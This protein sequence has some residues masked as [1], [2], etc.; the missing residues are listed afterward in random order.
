[1]W[2]KPDASAQTLVDQE[3]TIPTSSSSQLEDSGCDVSSECAFDS[4]GAASA[5][6]QPERDGSA[7]KPWLERA[8]PLNLCSPS[9]EKSLAASVQFLQH[10]LEIRQL[11]EGGILQADFTELEKDSLAVCSSV[12]RLLEG[13]TVFYSQPAFPFSGFL[14]EAVG[15]LVRVLTD[16]KLSNHVLKKCFRKLEEFEKSLIQVILRASSVNRLQA[17]WDLTQY[18]NI[19]P[20]CMVL[21]QLLQ[22]EAEGS[23]VS[24]PECDEGGKSRFLEDLD[25]VVLRLSD[26]FPLFSICL[27][28][29][30]VLLNPAPAPV[31]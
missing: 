27:W 17:E 10:L 25:R 4:L 24:S 2:G 15:V 8:L 13:L 6:H 14:T 11:S 1:M 23:K 28:R 26:E 18:E 21:E 31:D 12:S 5:L 29:V 9:R 30:S 16:T 20:L 19:F 3:C 7:S 22:K